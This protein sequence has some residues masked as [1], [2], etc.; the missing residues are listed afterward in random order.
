MYAYSSTLT[1]SSASRICT[2]QN[3]IF[4]IQYMYNNY[5]YQ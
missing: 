3:F 2:A 4:I 1:S 5:N